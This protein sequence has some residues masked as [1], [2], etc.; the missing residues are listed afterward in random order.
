[1]GGTCTDIGHF[2]IAGGVLSECL[3]VVISSHCLNSGG[4][5]WTV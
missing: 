5:F 1:M 3:H 2:Y 4:L